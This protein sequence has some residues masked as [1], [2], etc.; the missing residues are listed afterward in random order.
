MG[1]APPTPKCGKCQTPME[2]KGV[3]LLMRADAPDLAQAFK[4][5]VYV[6]PKGSCSHVEYYRPQ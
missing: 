5:K 4:V 1:L 3:H 6:C 2:D